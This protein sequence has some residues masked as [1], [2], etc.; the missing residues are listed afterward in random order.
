MLKI[1]ARRPDS[2]ANEKEGIDLRFGLIGYGLWGKHHA[3][4][5]RK[6]PGAVL[7]A[8]ACSSAETEAAAKADFPELPVY[9]GFQTLLDHADI[10]AVDIVVPSH[11]HAEIGVAALKAGKDVLL[12]K[13]MALSIAECD[14]LI[15]A[16]RRTKR[17]LTIGH[18]FRLSTQWGFLKTAIDAGDIGVPL[19]ALVT[20]FRFPYR[21]GSNRRSS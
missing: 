2:F 19:Y 10:E 3:Q 16:A 7:S 1:D 12:E 17:V 21:S 5:I 9:R 8:I 13:P 14:R 11:L 18:E 6:A 4:A 15:E 20:L